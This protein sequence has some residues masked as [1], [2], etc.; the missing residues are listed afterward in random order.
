MAAS[1]HADRQA[2]GH[3]GVANAGGS[4]GCSRRDDAAVVF[5]DTPNDFSRDQHYRL[6]R[7]KHERGRGMGGKTNGWHASTTRG[8]PEMSPSP[9]TRR[10]RAAGCWTPTL[11][12]T[13]RKWRRRCTRA[14]HTAAGIDISTGVGV[15]LSKLGLAGARIGV[16][17]IQMRVHAGCGSGAGAGAG[18]QARAGAA[19]H[20]R[21]HTRTHAHSRTCSHTF[22]SVCGERDKRRGVRVFSPFLMLQSE[23]A[24]GRTSQGAPWLPLRA[25]P[26][27]VPTTPR[28]LASLA[29]CWQAEPQA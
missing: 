4:S 21:R 29:A 17:F 5:A 22:A 28:W 7:Q 9:S 16:D 2:R 13:S 19:T 3:P 11:P 26:N 1:C 12:E 10:R 23:R 24:R 14:Q 20:A 27:Q 15:G 8:F 6:A 25:T 18:S